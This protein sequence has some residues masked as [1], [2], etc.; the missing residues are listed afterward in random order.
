MP[1]WEAETETETISP[2]QD[3]AKASTVIC[4]S[5]PVALKMISNLP[6]PNDARS[7]VTLK[8]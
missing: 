5:I 2:T 7:A 1:I 4:V 3:S 8:V 6:D